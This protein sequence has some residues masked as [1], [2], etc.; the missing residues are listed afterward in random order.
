MKI[1]VSKLMSSGAMPALACVLLCLFLAYPLEAKASSSDANHSEANVIAT[2]DANASTKDL[3]IQRI[4]PAGDEVDPTSGAARQI[5]IQFNRPV[6]PIGQMSRNASELPITF[7]HDLGCEWR[8]LNTSALACQIAENVLLAP[9]T[10]YSL[11]IKPGI[12]A[13]D[14]ETIAQ[15]Y[16]HQFTTQRPDITYAFVRVWESPERPVLRVAFNQP[17]TQSSVEAHVYYGD[18]EPGT[19]IAVTAKPDKELRNPTPFWVAIEQSIVGLFT[20]AQPEAEDTDLVMVNG[21]EARRVWLLTPA[22]ELE[23]SHG[24]MLRLEPGIASAYGPELSHVT[25]DVR[26]LETLPEFAFKGVSCTDND[27]NPLLFEPYKAPPPRACNP[28]GS[29]NLVFTSPV[30]RPQLAH[31]LKFEPRLAGD[32][33]SN[34]WGDPED[35]YSQRFGEYEKGRE[36]STWL[37]TTLKAAK[38]YQIHEQNNGFFARLWNQ[39]QGW[40]GDTPPTQLTDEFGRTLQKPISISFATDHR[41]PNY[42]LPYDAAVLEQQV[43]SEIPL[44]VNNLENFTFDY[45]ALD[46]QGARTKQTLTQSLPFVQDLQFAVPLGLRSMLNGRSGAVYGVLSTSPSVT[47]SG[48]NVRTSPLFAQVT[49][50]AMHVKLGHF[51]SLIWVTDFATGLPVEG[52]DVSAYVD[53]LTELKGPVA[54]IAK[55]KTNMQ[56]IALLPGT[57]TLDADLLRSRGWQDK[58]E[59]RLFF[60]ARKGDMQAILPIIYDFEINTY[61]AAG[62]DFSTDKRTKYGH[63]RSWGMTAQGV[64]R[65]GDTIDYKLYVR[66]DNG[67]QLIAPPKGVYNKSIT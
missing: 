52:V 15:T 58:S 60:A 57:D 53:T 19:R 13:E 17:V 27:G 34:F 45:N 54:A 59:P 56:G 26:T 43:D 21:E 25:R 29:I 10:T 65:S 48:G 35:D 12:T 55:Q 39:I 5:V 8:W 33:E 23:G 18:N 31:T 2:S 40:F 61:R 11:S 63:M 6:V 24:Y 44:W 36:Y 50:Y 32:K 20:P 22:D 47:D 16:A 1:A 51:Q 3:T 28:L 41:K 66:Q 9:S 49:P 14:G 46:T 42:E 7:S 62:E 67:K 4:I 64:Y 38:T 37:P 30:F